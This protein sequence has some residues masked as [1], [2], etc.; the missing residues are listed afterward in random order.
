MA[1]TI[2]QIKSEMTTAFM[3][4][5]TLA[6]SYGF[7]IGDTF[8][9]R[10]SVVS[11]ES[12]LFFIVAT[13]MWTLENLFDTHAIEMNHL[14]DTKKPHRL[15]WY[16]DKALAF[17]YSRALAEDQDVYDTIVESEK[18]VKY[19]SALEYAGR[20]YV[21]VAKGLGVKERLSDSELIAFKYYL[22]DVKDAGVV[23]ECVSKSA[24]HFRASITI[25]Y[26]PMVL[27]A[28]GV[29][30]ATGVEVVREAITDFVQNKIPFN[31]EY[32]NSDLVDSLQT[33]S[34]VVIPELQVASTLSAEAYTFSDI[35]WNIA[36]K[37][38]PDSG[39]FK[40]YTPSDLSLDYVAYQTSG[41]V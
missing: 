7:D 14:I 2:A 1:R 31:G 16:R 15:K 21:K 10:F 4:D 13:A 41:A 40:I 23:V 38:I 36:A 35:W 8:E 12:I 6:T 39:Y 25:Y 28:N 26:D 24:D 9:E 30:L 37:H 19:A 3:R 11:L 18:I 32:R 17:Q 27:D 5:A 33:V 20:V 29:S 22:N 34:G